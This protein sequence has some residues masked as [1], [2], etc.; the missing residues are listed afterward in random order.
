LCPAFYLQI[1]ILPS[2]R[3]W[4][5]TSDLLLVREALYP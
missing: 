2:G 1:A 4:V 3:C 5:R